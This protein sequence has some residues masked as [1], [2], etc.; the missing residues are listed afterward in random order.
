MCVRLD[1]EAMRE[2]SSHESLAPSPKQVGLT[3][4]R[5]ANQEA[6]QNHWE[7]ALSLYKFSLEEFVALLGPRHHVIAR[8]LNKIG[9]AYFALGPQ[10]DYD[11]F[12]AFEEALSIQ[13]DLLSPGDK[14]TANTL[15]NIWLM[16]RRKR[17]EMEYDEM[18]HI[19]QS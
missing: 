18:I 4:Y 15:R 12:S 16:L 2:I 11:A 1:A 6:D 17:E 5:R 10:Y 13:Q 8:T 7:D 3:I 9:I 19:I 14:D